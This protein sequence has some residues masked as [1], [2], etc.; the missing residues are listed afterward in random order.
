M[1]TAVRSST[2]ETPPLHDLGFRVSPAYA[3]VR[4]YAIVGI[5][6]ACAGNDLAGSC[7]LRPFTVVLPLPTAAS[8]KHWGEPPPYDLRFRV[9]PAYEG[10]RLCAI[11]WIAFACA[12]HDLAGSCEIGPYH[13][14]L[15]LPTENLDEALG[16]A[17]PVRFR[18]SDFPCT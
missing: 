4:V 15:P 7:E 18:V 13:I 6:F 14:A 1:P 9:S 16:G 2:G 17:A 5:A 8:T 3:G 12:G 10:V 11:V